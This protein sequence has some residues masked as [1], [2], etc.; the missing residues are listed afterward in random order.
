MAAAPKL[1]E[2]QAKEYV[3]KTTAVSILKLKFQRK[4]I[5]DSGVQNRPQ[6][7]AEV[8][9]GELMA[10]IPKATNGGANQY[11]AKSTAVSQKRTKAEAIKEAGFTQMQKQKR[12][13][14][15]V[16]SFERKT[17]TEQKIDRT[18]VSC[19]KLKFQRKSA[20]DSSVQSRPQI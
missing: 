8:K 16:P 17:K 6:T 19:L 9:I 12:Q 4:S 1:E 15:D 3:S 7:K 13:D 2:A 11:Q 18:A 14:T 5:L 20:M 10:Q